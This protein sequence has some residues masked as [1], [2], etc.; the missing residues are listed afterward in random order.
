MS[1]DP[2]PSSPLGSAPPAPPSRPPYASEIL[3]AQSA[4]A[5]AA[6]PV[7]AAP[8]DIAPK[9]SHLIL[10]FFGGLGAAIVGA[11]IWAAIAI[12][13]TLEV[14]YV[15]V[16]LAFLVGFTVR[17]LGKGNTKAYGVIGALC[18]L[19]GIFLGKVFIV[20]WFVSDKESVSMLTV[21]TH[22]NWGVLL[23]VI[24]DNLGP[25]DYFFGAFAL[26]LGFKYSIRS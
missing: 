19:F 14:G 20:L 25:I 10:S 15:A 18:S 21:A 6:D 2:P 17:Y 23:S 1:D 13:T 24:G 3:A 12:I 11:I 9:A 26:Y 22:V 4:M 8:E 7:A 16:G 5:D